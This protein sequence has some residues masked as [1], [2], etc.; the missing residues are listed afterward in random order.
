MG[1]VFV[2]TS[3]KGGVGK[4]TATATLGTCLASMGNK[5][6]LI[7]TDIGQR[8]LDIIL[9][10]EDRIVYDLIDVLNGLVSEEQAILKDRNT[11]GLYLLPAAQT[12]SSDDLKEEAM[13]TLCERLKAKY[14]YI[15]IDAPA[16]IDHGFR[17]AIAGA[18][19][20]I[21]VVT[22]ELSSVRDAERVIGILESECQ[23]P[24]ERMK[25]LINRMR[26]KLKKKM[27]LMSEED[28]L[29][30]LG[31]PLCGIVPEDERVLI[32]ASEGSVVALDPRSNA[33]KAYYN[34]ARRL[35]GEEIALLDTES[36]RLK[37]LF[38]QLFC[39]MG[40]KRV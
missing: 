20:A 3:G 12:K 31:I 25:L 9:G 16:G 26:S 5:V 32:G 2:V 34:T 6:L 17:C 21:I 29:A 27:K 39:H 40:N 14:D 35:T 10:L 36:G 38:R 33:G 30:I 19:S 13:A 24:T 37:V 22:P 7:D 1:E 4:S 8:N 18:Q 15:F 28:I 23:I 11:P